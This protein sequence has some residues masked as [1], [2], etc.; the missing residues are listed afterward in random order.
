MKL[1]KIFILLIIVINILL[2]SEISYAD[3][4]TCFWVDPVN[5]N[6]SSVGSEAEPFL[7]I[8]KARQTVRNINS[9]MQNDIF[10]YLK[11]GI[12]KISDTMVFDADDSGTNG[13][14]VV[15]CAAPGEKPVISGGEEITGWS[16]YD[17]ENNIYCADVP[18]NAKDSRSFYVDGKPAK[19]AYETVKLHQYE[20]LVMDNYKSEEFASA[21]NIVSVIIDLEETV[22]DIKEIC[23][24]AGNILA[25]DGVSIAGFPCD[26]TISVSD[27]NIDYSV[28]KE[29]KGETACE[30]NVEKS[31]E[32]KNTSARYIKLDVTK[33]GAPKQSVFFLSL[34]EI[35]IFVDSRQYFPDFTSVVRNDYSNNIAIGMQAEMPSG[36]STYDISNINDGSLDT[37]ISS[38]S[39][40]NPMLEHTLIISAEDEFTFS[41]IRLF[42]VYNNFELVNEPVDFSLYISNDSK[43]WVEIAKVT[44]AQWEYGHPYTLKLS[45]KHNAK[46]IKLVSNRIGH[47]NGKY[48]LQLAEIEIIP[49]ANLALAMPCEADSSIE[50][51]SWSLERLT[52]GKLGNGFYSCKYG[53]KSQ[54][55]SDQYIAVDLKD[56]RSIGGIRLYPR[57]AYGVNIHF[58]DAI[59]VYASTDGINYSL[60][61]S[62]ENI[63]ETNGKPLELIFSD[64]VSAR[65][66]K[67]VPMRIKNGEPSNGNTNY[68]FQLAELEVLP[69]CYGINDLT[70]DGVNYGLG[71]NIAKTNVGLGKKAYS[72]S[73]YS[74]KNHCVNLTDGIL[75]PTGDSYY[76]EIT[77][78]NDF[79]ISND[80][81]SLEIHSSY[82]WYYNINKVKYVSDDKRFLRVNN[83]VSLPVGGSY[84]RV[85]QVTFLE[86]AYEL[87]D[88]EEEWYIDKNGVLDNSGNPKIYYKAPRNYDMSLAKTVI[89]SV[90][91]LIMLKGNLDKPIR[92][93][94]F[95][96][97]IFAYNTWFHP[98]RG[99]RD[100]QGG[101]YYGDAVSR[102]TIKTELLNDQ[103]D[104]YFGLSQYIT[105][106]LCAVEISYA[107]NVTFSQNVFKNLGS[108]GL[109]VHKASKNCNI[110][111]NAF[112][113]ISG[114]AIFIGNINDHHYYEINELNVV[115]NNVVS[116]NY[117]TRIGIDYNDTA[118]IVIGYTEG[119][120][121][122]HNEIHDVPY[123]GI[124]C[125]WGWGF[126]DANDTAGYTTSTC[127]KNNI[128]EYNKIYDI[129]L[130]QYDGGGIYTLGEQ[131]NSIIRGNYID[132]CGIDGTAIYL[133]Q[134]S[135]GF[136]VN[137]N[138][139]GKAYLW[140][141]MWAEGIENNTITN[142]YYATADYLNNVPY[143]NRVFNNIYIPNYDFSKYTAAQNIINNSGLQTE[144]Y[145]IKSNVYDR[146]VHKFADQRIRIWSWN[147]PVGGSKYR[148]LPYDSKNEEVSV[149]VDLG[150]EKTINSVE[151]YP[152][153]SITNVVD[154][155]IHNCNY[156]DLSASGFPED[157]TIECSSDGVNYK[158]VKTVVNESTPKNT[159]VLT[160]E[161]ETCNARYIKINAT[162][163]G[164]SCDSE[165]GVYRLELSNIKGNYKG[166]IKYQNYLTSDNAPKS[167]IALNTKC[168]VDNTEVSELTDGNLITGLNCIKKD[169][170]LLIEL[171]EKTIIS[172]M[173]LKSYLKSGFVNG[174]IGF[175]VFVSDND[176]EYKKVATISNTVWDTSL[177]LSCKFPA[178]SAKF[179]K[180][181]IT[182]EFLGEKITV[183]EIEIYKGIKNLALNKNV[184]KYNNTNNSLKVVSDNNLTDGFAYN[185]CYYSSKFDSNNPDN[186]SPVID[187]G[188]INDI[189]G[190]RLYPQILGESNTNVNYPLEILI[191]TSLDGKE[192]NDVLRAKYIPDSFGAPQDYIFDSGIKAR[193]VQ[194]VPLALCNDE[195]QGYLC[196]SECEIISADT[197]LYSDIFT[198]NKG[199]TIY[200][201]LSTK[202]NDCYYDDFIVYKDE[203]SFFCQNSKIDR[204]NLQNYKNEVI[205]ISIPIE[206]LSENSKYIKT[207]VCI[208]DND[209]KIKSIN[210]ADEIRLEYR[211]KTIIDFDVVLNNIY[212]NDKLELYI[213]LDSEN[214]EAITSKMVVI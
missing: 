19:R 193:Y 107:E 43:S 9:D 72:T 32:V 80:I 180:I 111:G 168:F 150:I 68:R 119:T 186:S 79:R 192:F 179:I 86:N 2:L 159:D 48:R 121:V 146:V 120:V 93:I 207:I 191:R 183:D 27:D 70:F 115:K 3:F 65:Y 160:Y 123:T 204:F 52:D 99:L 11:S 101:Y 106:H 195:A 149:T 97:I 92:N 175:D 16:L 136:M 38:I 203:I 105:G 169:S 83:P 155:S 12:H 113:D 109:R 26:F 118:A 73:L 133:D 59:N 196:L 15:Y 125:G 85:E 47:S 14:N 189:I 137:D 94:R 202:D 154:S 173:V 156:W 140:Y 46:H 69:Y 114:G 208:K 54:N 181:I 205:R 108:A 163:L 152:G 134:G 17:K 61:L 44:D 147:V 184:Y 96:G 50:S 199:M 145:G 95:E 157:F 167:N 78:Q 5:G 128:I 6:D 141:S 22:S 130:V 76:Y 25:D 170:A 103:G 110:I 42:G 174:R 102:D 112:Y 185:N 162:K 131:P 29:V 62:L 116:N 164:E 129:M 104:N 126:Y 89:P 153:Y 158:V 66:L 172:E 188:V 90:E 148:S 39:S 64:M 182:S 210:F 30:V 212:E 57:S 190:V 209:G 10:I 71:S 67:I 91:H 187:M 166:Y 214:M 55:R 124:S 34:A 7:T 176:I 177:P 127:A 74:L 194:I 45:G 53:E 197:L 37:I 35:R 178:V 135:T 144:Y 77:P 20:N 98:N 1:S 165:P 58:P 161:F 24:C 171:D 18:L 211:E 117:I 139:I 122:S 36:D 82:L 151:L 100:K 60:D 143:D 33:L 28:V 132:C 51:D 56:I 206:S 4:P 201:K 75:K 13:F 213:W 200:S 21:D 81:S 138:V 40:R 84:H 87:I 198:D 8:E 31:Y 142:C 23:L 49:P 63:P 88:E 41:A